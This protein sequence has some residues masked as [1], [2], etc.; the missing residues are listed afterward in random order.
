MRSENS[1]QAAAAAGGE[2]ARLLS[3][4]S[5]SWPGGGSGSGRQGDAMFWLTA[6]L[7]VRAAPWS[8]QP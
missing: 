3:V 7:L 4:G 5:G 2:A 1:L 6:A 8:P